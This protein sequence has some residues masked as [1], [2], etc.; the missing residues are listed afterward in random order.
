[1]FFPALHDD[2]RQARVLCFCFH[3]Q[4][5]SRKRH[6]R[7]SDSAEPLVTLDEQPRKTRQKPTIIATPSRQSAG[8]LEG[9]HQEGD[10]GAGTPSSEGSSIQMS[11][12][13][14]NR[15]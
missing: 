1:M 4:V 13:P 7:S 8:F 14:I 9:Q 5:Q 15:G 11:S 3:L 12:F 2:F 10:S 6:T